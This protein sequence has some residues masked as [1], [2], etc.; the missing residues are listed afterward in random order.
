MVCDVFYMFSGVAWLI[1]L[2]DFCF[3]C[4]VCFLF[5]LWLVCFACMLFDRLK[6]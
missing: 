6:I 1:L 3:G 5:M 4:H 2:V